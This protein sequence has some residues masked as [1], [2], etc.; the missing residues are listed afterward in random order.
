MRELGLFAQVQFDEFEEFQSRALQAD[1]VEVWSTV[2]VRFRLTLY[3]CA[4]E[5]MYFKPHQLS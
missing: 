2:L 3:L 5:R 1:L 4:D